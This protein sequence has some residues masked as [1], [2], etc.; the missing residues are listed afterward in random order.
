MS[1]SEIRDKKRFLVRKITRAII[2]VHEK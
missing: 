1:K 2:L